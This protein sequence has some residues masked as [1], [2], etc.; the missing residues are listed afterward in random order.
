M[1]RNRLGHPTGPTMRI[2]GKVVS[3]ITA[4]Y[5]YR[6]AECLGA[7]EY[8]NAG[9]RC[10]TSSAHRGFV[11]KSEAARLRAAQQKNIKQLSEVYEIV[12]GKVRIKNEHQGTD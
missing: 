4:R 3:R 6:C 2:G 1:K 5:D 8:W 9:V 12:D 10:A 11:H 7:L